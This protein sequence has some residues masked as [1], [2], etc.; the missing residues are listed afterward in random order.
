M[1]FEY[2]DYFDTEPVVT[3]CGVDISNEEEEH[4][5]RNLEIEAEERKLEETLEYQRRIECEAKE[6]LLAEQH[7]RSAMTTVEKNAAV[8]CPDDHFRNKDINKHVP[9]ALQVSVFN[10]A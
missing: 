8:D 6:K 9:E 5:R 3:G 4:Q 7:K 1:A 2:E 10:T